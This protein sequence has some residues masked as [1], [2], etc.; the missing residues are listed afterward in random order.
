[1]KSVIP[2]LAPTNIPNGSAHFVNPLLARIFLFA[3]ETVWASLHAMT[4]TLALSVT[5]AAEALVEN[6]DEKDE[7]L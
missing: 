7:K 6:I 5:F 4:F 1:M 3:A 2:L